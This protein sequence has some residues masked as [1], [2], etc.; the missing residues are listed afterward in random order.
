[1]KLT[2]KSLFKILLVVFVI[3]IM[4]LVLLGLAE[5][6]LPANRITHECKPPISGTLL[7]DPLY[8]HPYDYSPWN[9]ERG[10]CKRFYHV[11]FKRSWDRSIN[12]FAGVAVVASGLALVPVGS[13]LLFR[14]ASTRKK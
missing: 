11:E 1:M 14:K 7:S 5:S 10:F 9:Y 12:N 4:A 8:G 2:A 3:G 13:V 6:Y